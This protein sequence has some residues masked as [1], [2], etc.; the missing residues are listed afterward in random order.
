MYLTNFKWKIF[1]IY[2]S[3]LD[4]WIPIE[5]KRKIPFFTH[6]DK[7]T[8]ILPLLTSYTVSKAKIK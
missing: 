1:A 7:K 2:V 3:K 6:F 4:S 5:K 8:E